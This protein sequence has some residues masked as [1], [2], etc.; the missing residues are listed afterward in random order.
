MEGA[1]R[2]VNFLTLLA[3]FATQTPFGLATLR[4]AGRSIHGYVD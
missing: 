3:S 1:R 4:S 2:G